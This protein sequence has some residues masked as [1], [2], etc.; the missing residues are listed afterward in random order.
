MNDDNTI[1]EWWN[2]LTVEQQTEALT[3]PDKLPAWMPDSEKAT[4][5]LANWQP[6]EQQTAEYMSVP[7]REFLEAK[8]GQ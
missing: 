3:I 8:R 6:G 1:N 5:I 4:E 7:L 2:S